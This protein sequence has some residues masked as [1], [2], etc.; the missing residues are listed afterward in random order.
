M[1]HRVEWT[2]ERVQRFWNFYTTG[3][4]TREV[5]FSRR[6]GR[7]IIHLAQRHGKLAGPVVDFGCGPGDLVEELLRLGFPCKAIDV[8]AEAVDHVQKRFA[9]RPG[10]L[11]A[12]VGSLEQLPLQDG[13]AGAIFLIEVLEHLTPESAARACAEFRRVLQSG[14]HLILTVPNEE[15][16][17]ANAVA[18]PDCGCIF[19]RMQHVQRFSRESLSEWLVGVGFEPIFVA[20]LHL[21]HFAG[22]WMIRPIGL[23]NHLVRRLRHRANPHLV[24]IAR[25]LPT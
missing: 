3:A 16:L 4:A 1:Y 22:R 13:E 8:S 19:H 25:L 17:Q 14:G 12:C 23:L 18:C 9:G 5:Y 15:D 21:K 10:F 2:P 20:G 7:A 11:G 6:F 24:A